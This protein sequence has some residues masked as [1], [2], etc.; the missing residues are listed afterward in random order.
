MHKFSMEAFWFHWVADP[1]FLTE[2][3]VT[4]RIVGMVA[5]EAAARGTDAGGVQHNAVW[6][7]AD[8]AV[9][10]ANNAASEKVLFGGDDPPPS[11]ESAEEQGRG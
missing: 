10:A 9:S 6:P 8:V 1:V 3:E 5:E 11:S 7:P 2:V 4:A